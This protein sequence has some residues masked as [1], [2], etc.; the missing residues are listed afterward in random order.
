MPSYRRETFISSLGKN[1]VRFKGER[2]KFCSRF[3]DV[4]G[5]DSQDH[6][7]IG[8]QCTLGV[9]CL[10]MFL[11]GEGAVFKCQYLGVEV[12]H[13]RRLSSP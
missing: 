5:K 12:P 4:Y 7:K 9:L 13:V 3:Y 2:W 8:P 1:G 6:T 10:A 11:F